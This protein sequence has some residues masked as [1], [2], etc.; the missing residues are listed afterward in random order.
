MKVLFAGTPGVRKAVALANLSA[1]IELLFPGER[2]AT[3]P[4]IEGVPML[5]RPLYGSRPITFLKLSEERRR[6]RWQETF[7]DVTRELE[8]SDAPHQFL[9][10]HLIHRHRN[11]PSC[12]VSIPDVVD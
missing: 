7:R 3:I 11:A 6:L 2:I 10:V 1:T 9:G 8:K 4:G 5:D 12:M